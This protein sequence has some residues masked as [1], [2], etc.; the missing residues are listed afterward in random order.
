MEK[1]SAWIPQSITSVSDRLS[2]VVLV[3]WCWHSLRPV[4]VPKPKTGNLTSEFRLLKSCPTPKNVEPLTR[5]IREHLSCGHIRRLLC[6]NVH[7]IRR[8]HWLEAPIFWKAEIF[9]PRQRASTSIFGQHSKFM[10]QL[11][12]NWK[13]PSLYFSKLPK[14]YTS[15]ILSYTNVCSARSS[16]WHGVILYKSVWAKIT[17]KQPVR[18]RGPPTSCIL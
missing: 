3:P 5:A 4:F 17:I 18:R 7:H 8:K 10:R 11:H 2:P 1:V 12:S 14:F 9:W 16:L 6:L 13:I 15:Y